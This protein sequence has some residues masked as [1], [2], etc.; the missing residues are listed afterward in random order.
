MALENNQPIVPGYTLC[1]GQLLYKGRLVIP[2]ASEWV[3]QFLQEFH[4]TPIGGHS[5]FLRT[6]KRIASNLFWTGMKADIM[7]YVAECIICQQHKYQ[8]TSPAGLLVLPTAVWEDVSLDFVS[9][10]PRS[11]GYDTLLVVLDF[12]SGLPRSQVYA[13]EIAR[14][15]GMPRE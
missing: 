5:G 8:A 1:H 11:Q 10:L 12:V 9:G 2:A 14:L 6:Y 4:S 13:K 15:H 7:K 3:T